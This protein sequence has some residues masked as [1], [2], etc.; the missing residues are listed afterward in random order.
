MINHP[1]MPLLRHMADVILDHLGMAPLVG[2]RFDPF[3][4]HQLPV[5][6]SVAQGY[7]L[8]WCD[9][10]TR[11]YMLDRD[12]RFEEYVT[13]Y[14]R[15]YVAKYGYTPYPETPASSRVGAWRRVLRRAATAFRH[16]TVAPA[17]SKS[18]DAS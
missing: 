5:H 13:V 14:I 7:G 4:M 17:M 1:A 15:A 10:D 12:Y 8:A 9:A 3:G 16:Q 11:Y 2:E 18:G 6:P